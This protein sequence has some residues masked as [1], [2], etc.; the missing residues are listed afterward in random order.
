MYVILT[1]GI[2]VISLIIGGLIG[3]GIQSSYYRKSERSSKTSTKVILDSMDERIAEIKD[4]LRTSGLVARCCFAVAPG[5]AA[6]PI[7]R[8]RAEP[9][10]RARCLPNY[11]GRPATNTARDGA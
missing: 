3:L 5:G 10:V 11:R 9:F 7:A 2:A 1:V 8:A 6:R 4:E